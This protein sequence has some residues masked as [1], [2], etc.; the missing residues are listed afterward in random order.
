MNRRS[1]YPVLN[2]LKQSFPSS[3]IFPIANGQNLLIFVKGLLLFLDLDERT[4]NRIESQL[5]KRD[6]KNLRLLTL[7]IFHSIIFVLRETTSSVGNGMECL[8]SLRYN[9]KS[10]LN[11]I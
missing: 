2:L 1:V 3:E 7:V 4:T 8:C 10:T 9:S 5:R 11:L 6:A